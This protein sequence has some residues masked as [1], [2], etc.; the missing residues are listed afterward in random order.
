MAEFASG[1][2]AALVAMSSWVLAAA[3]PAAAQDPRSSAAQAAALAWVK[4][5]DADDAAAT[6]GQASQRFRAAITRERWADSLKKA[7]ENFGPV[8]RRTHASTRAPGPGKDTPP[9]EFLMLVFR[10]EFGRRGQGTETMT[11]EREPD[12]TWRVFGYLMR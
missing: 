12:G 11:M 4:L 9:G 5:A 3:V 8:V 6:Y 10:T 1:R 7:R 2:R